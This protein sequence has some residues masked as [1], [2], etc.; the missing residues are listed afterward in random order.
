[1]KKATEAGGRNIINIMLY[2]IGI[3]DTTYTILHTVL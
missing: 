1:M 2:A 3:A